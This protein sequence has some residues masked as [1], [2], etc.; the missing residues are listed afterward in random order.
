MGN[1]F[2]RTVGVIGLLVVAGL[3]M[4]YFNQGRLL[5]LP[6][7]PGVPE[8]P[9]DNPRGYRSPEEHGL[10]YE[11]INTKADDGHP[12]LAWLVKAD[13][14]SA[15]AP[16]LVFF[17]GNAGN[18]ALRMPNIV[19]L[20][21]RLRTNVLMVEYRGYGDVPGTPDEAGMK[22]DAEAAV[23]ALLSRTDIH[24]ERI[25][26]FG[27]S[28]G[29]AVS[30]AVAD[31][32]ADKLAGVVVEN[33]FTSISAMVDV[34]FP[35]LSS[36]KQYLLTLRWDSLAVV[37][38]LDLPLLFVS[39]EQDELVPPKH[40]SQLYDASIVRAAAARLRWPRPL[41]LWLPLTRTHSIAAVKE[42]APVLGER[43][44]A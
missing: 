44:Q 5:Y 31:R 43:R 10:R 9:A 38:R 17:H 2:G 15:A 8:R 26:L 33:T 39:G 11:V 13:E 27:R 6:R 32:M 14:G 34:L 24:S 12:V 22:V 30:F 28:L 3:I 16:T 4:L 42:E 7:M 40:M 25:F 36:L 23:G 37:R 19:S 29:G 18:F 1:S 21:R 20:V 41:Q 35:L